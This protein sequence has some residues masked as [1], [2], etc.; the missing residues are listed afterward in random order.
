MPVWRLQTTFHYDTGL[1]RDGMVITPHFDDGGALTDPQGLCADLAAALD[2]LAAVKTQITV[3]AY[4]AQG[5]VPVFPQGEAQ[6]RTGTFG[7]SGGPREV[8]L[9]LSFFAE[10]NL[11]RTRG[12]LYFPH[13]F[14]SAGSPS[15]IR[16][17]QILMESLGMAADVFQELGGTDV[18][19]VV[20]SGRD[21]AARP[22]TDWF[23][24]DEWDT[25]RSR[26]LRPNTRVTGT[27]SE[28]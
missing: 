1:P 14:I 22:V 25:I 6:V 15:G 24:D 21:D 4:D 9:C 18:D 28:G 7:S 19:W 11:P 2:D 3:K 13:A 5:T 16:P 10:R 8:A 23:V 27:T 20:Y 12:R 26:G 17:T